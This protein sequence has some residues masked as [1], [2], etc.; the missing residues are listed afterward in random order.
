MIFRRKLIS[1]A[2]GLVV[3]C[4]TFA[5]VTMATAGPASASPVITI[6]LTNASAFCADV[7]DSDNVSGQPIWLY[8][9]QDGAKDYHWYEVP[10]YCPTM[11]SA[12]FCACPDQN[13]ILFEDVQ[14][15]SLCLAATPTGA[16]IELINCQYDQG[17]TARA[18]W[19]Q[20]GNKLE[21]EFQGGTGFLTVTGPLFSG[22]YLYTDP[23][24]ASG[25][26]EWQ[27]WSGP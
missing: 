13:C 2:A 16:G 24:V 17:G 7:K 23:P 14:N 21:N 6:C 9:P 12:T 8:R 27:Q 18:E 11:G 3:T 22:R 26:N 20:L 5:G 10:S 25:G 19:V 15:P 1:L 4:G